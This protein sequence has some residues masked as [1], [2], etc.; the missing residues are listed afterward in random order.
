MLFHILTAGGADAYSPGHSGCPAH[1][2]RP[3]RGG[4]VGE[5]AHPGADDTIAP[6]GVEL[7]INGRAVRPP[8]L[9]ASLEGFVLETVELHRGVERYTERATRVDLYLPRLG[10]APHLFELR[11]PVEP[12]H[13]PWHVD[14][15]QRL[16]LAAERDV[17][18]EPLVDRPDLLAP[19]AE[20]QEADGVRQ[21]PMGTRGD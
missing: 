1:S 21:T 18:R 8:R 12:H 4:R 3:A 2:T 13:L 15:Q 20:P 9:K 16:P 17:T 19:Y 11:L 14:V 6:P 7:V 5:G 10:E